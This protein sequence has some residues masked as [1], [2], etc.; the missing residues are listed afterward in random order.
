[1]VYVYYPFNILSCFFYNKL[2]KNKKNTTRTTYSGVIHHYTIVPAS[3]STLRGYVTRPLSPTSVVRPA[4][5]PT[6]GTVH[7]SQLRL[8][9]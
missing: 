9:L 1:M 6:V 2:M 7:R 8:A 3:T 4:P 5:G